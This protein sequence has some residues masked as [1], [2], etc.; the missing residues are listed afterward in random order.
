M[1]TVQTLEEPSTAGPTAASP[2]PVRRRFVLPVAVGVVFVAL[3]ALGLW[4]RLV[5]N[6]RLAAAAAGSRSAHPRVTVAPVRPGPASVDLEL[7]ANVE[8]LSD[9]AIHARAD[10]YVRRR[11]AD[12]GD[13]VRAGQVL[14]EIESPELAEQIRQAAATDQRARAG[15]RQAE[16]S[17]EQGRVNRDLA[18]VTLGRWQTLVAK[19]VLSKQDGDE[20]Q[21]A[22]RARQADVAAGEAAVAGARE[23]LQAAEA[24]HRRL[25]ELQGFRQIRAPFDGIVTVRNVDVG[26]LVTAGSGSSVTP[27]F[28]LA[29]LDR[30]RA[31]INVPQGE[32]SA[33]RAGLEC[34]VEVR[35][36]GGRPFKGRVTRTSSA[37]DPSTRTLLAEIEMAN[38]DSLMLPGMS[39]TVRIALRRERPPLLIPA[40]AFQTGEAGP[41]VAVI[42]THGI[43]HFRHVRLGRD[44][45]AQ[46]EV[47]E[48]LTAGE[49]VATS[50]SDALREGA[51]VEPVTPSAPAAPGNGPAR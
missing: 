45:G 9:V 32:A 40:T 31:H 29:A 11:Q 2:P 48:G 12:I 1:S 14:A 44:N 6:R 39:A 28:R 18:E 21:A 38:P 19:G 35:E 49:R 16:A 5:Q 24:D 42:D 33:V 47:L 51:T 15:L 37:L 30:L 26:A 4:P 20:K 25:R 22:F 36:L 34:T 50:I 27:L 13:R 8:A 43:V 3:L 10:G 23:A 7:P 41:R 46:I 17:A